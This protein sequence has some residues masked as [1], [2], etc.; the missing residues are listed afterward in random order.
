[1]GGADED[2]L[3]NH[4][5]STVKCRL[6]WI[7]GFQPPGDPPLQEGSMQACFTDQHHYT[8]STQARGADLSVFI[9]C[10]NQPLTCRCAVN[11]PGL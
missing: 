7:P 8:Y 11:P 9:A 6:Q 4:A 2:S 3:Q 5:P 10:T 1:M